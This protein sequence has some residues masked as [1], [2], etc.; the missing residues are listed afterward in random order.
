MPSKLLYL[1]PLLEV[2]TKIGTMPIHLGNIMYIEARSK[3][4]IIHLDDLSIFESCHMLKWYQE[5]LPEPEFLRCHNS[6]I[7]NC[8]YVQSYIGYKFIL[9]EKLHVPVSRNKYQY[10]K[11]NIAALKQ[12]IACQPFPKD[13]MYSVLLQ[14]TS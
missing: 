1:L 2:K 7:V 6:I 9:G 3:H 13:A 14:S 10:C 4:S 8:F 11:D 12:K 5:R